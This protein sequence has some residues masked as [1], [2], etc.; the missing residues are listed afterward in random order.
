MSIWMDMTYSLSVW[1]G[2]LI[3]IIRAELE[4][5]KNLHE[6]NKDIRFCRATYNGFVEIKSNEL[7]WLWNSNNTGDAYMLYMGRSNEVV[8][9]KTNKEV[10]KGLETAYAYSA[11]RLDRIKKLRD[12]LISRSPRLLKP[13][14]AMLLYVLYSPIKLVSMS[15][16]LILHGRFADD[17][18]KKK[19]EEC[20]LKVHPFKSEDIIFAAGWYSYNGIIKEK[21]FSELKNEIPDITVCYLVYDLVLANPATAPLYDAK[22][23]FERYLIWVNNNCDYIFYGG[24]T[25]QDDAEKFYEKNEFP[26][27]KGYF[28]RFGSGV[29][30]KIGDISFENLRKRYKLE[31]NYI[32]SVGTV[33]AKKNYSTLYHAYTMMSDKYGK[34]NIPQLVIVGG[35]YGDPALSESMEIDPAIKGKIVFTRPSDDELIALYNNCKFTVL[36]TWYEGW[37]LTLPESLMYGKFC[38][39]SDVAPLREIAK[40][41]VDYVAPDDVRMWADKIMYYMNNPHIVEKY[42]TNIIKEYKPISWLDCA[43]DLNQKLLE[44]SNSLREYPDSNIIYDLSLAFYSAQ[45]GASVSGILRTQLL[46]ARQLGRYF[47]HLRFAVLTE[48]KSFFIDRFHLIDLLIEHSIDLSYQLIRPVMVYMNE[49]LN[50]K[51]HVRCNPIY[52]DAQIFWMFASILPGKVRDRL[53]DRA[54]KYKDNE[55]NKVKPG[56]TYKLPFHKEDIFLTTG[57]GYIPLIYNTLETEKERIGYKFI[58]L[59]YD[60]TPILYPQVHTE[61][62]LKLY[63]NF[64]E[65]SYKLSNELFYGGATA[66]RDGIEYAKKNKLPERKS[67]AVKFGSDIAVKIEEDESKIKKDLFKRLKIK[68]S[69]IMAVGSIEARKNHETLYLAY[70]NMLKEHE[71]D[72]PQMIFCGYPGWK[73]QEFIKRLNRDKRVRN[74]IIMYTPS[75]VEMDILYKNCDFT[76]LASLYEGWSLTLPESLNYNKLCIATDADPMREIGGDLLEYVSAFDVREWANKIWKYYNDKKLL[77]EKEE[78][79]RKNWKPISWRACAEQVAKE[80]ER[81]YKEGV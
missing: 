74:K 19:E 13:I 40:D 62:T 7:D 14:S 42:N 46:L 63:P 1:K 69:Y 29:A 79:I 72:I 30:K 60:Y 16:Q 22:E 3:G 65:K 20:V 8:T 18:S 76:V 73:T 34:E 15:R 38:L 50:N 26:I 54:V 44:I 59:I 56:S 25:A 47:P 37:S 17:P 48:S 6:L 35:K 77:E 31:D 53:I 41:M 21:L 11:G 33:D 39:C 9:N 10:P 49:K 5:A 4:M 36:P 23:Q 70:L 78:N 55:L 24:Q 61:Q 75:D 32:L 12:M 66:M 28:L 57:V 45:V 68:G 67:F 52:T 43:K 2:G 27:R 51:Q 64:L 80:L 81:V 58:Q 71:D